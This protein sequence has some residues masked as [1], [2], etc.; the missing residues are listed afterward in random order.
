MYRWILLLIVAPYVVLAT[1]DVVDISIKD[2]SFE[3]SVFTIPQ[4]SEYNTSFIIENTTTKILE[5]TIDVVGEETD[6][7][8]GGTIFFT[9]DLDEEYLEQLQNNNNDVAL[10][11]GAKH[12]DTNVQAWCEGVESIPVKI[13]AN[14]FVEVPIVMHIADDAK[15]HV[16]EIIVKKNEG[17]EIIGHKEIAY[18]VPDK[19]ITSIELKE[20]SM[21]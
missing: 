3:G 17:S 14:S 7:L 19:N 13:L 8:V 21:T 5:A 18:K 9:D 1:S 11:C 4:G 12:D 10:F 20:T 16:A 15:D 2:D 6:S